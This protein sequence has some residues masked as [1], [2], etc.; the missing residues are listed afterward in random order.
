MLDFSKKID[1]LWKKEKR[2]VVESIA[3]SKNEALTFLTKER[4]K[5]MRMRHEYCDLA[6]NRIGNTQTK[7]LQQSLL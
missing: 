2:V 1:D 7:S 6:R 3:V 4:E 5:I